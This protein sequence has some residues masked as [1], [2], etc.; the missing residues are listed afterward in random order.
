MNLQVSVSCSERPGEKNYRIRLTHTFAEKP[1]NI[2]TSYLEL[3][4]LYSEM[5]NEGYKIEGFPSPGLFSEWFGRS[6]P[7]REMEDIEGVSVYL[8][9]CLY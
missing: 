8:S 3:K 2:E 7:M 5:K 4:R 9:P 6:D 1:W